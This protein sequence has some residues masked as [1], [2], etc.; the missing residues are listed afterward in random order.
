MSVVVGSV[1]DMSRTLNAPL[2][3]ISFMIA[4]S[5]ELIGPDT[6]R[7]VIVNLLSPTVVDN[8]PAVD[9]VTV[10]VVSSARA[11]RQAINRNVTDKNILLMHK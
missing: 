1:A 11:D 8:V 2:V 3:A 7:F 6:V 9:N 4:T 5:V 10:F